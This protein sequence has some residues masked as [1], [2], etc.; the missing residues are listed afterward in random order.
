MRAAEA[1]HGLGRIREH[2]RAADCAIVPVT[3][4]GRLPRA[5]RTGSMKRST[6]IRTN[7]KSASTRAKSSSVGDLHRASR[8]RAP[9]RTGMPIARRA[10]HRRWPCTRSAFARRC[11]ALDHRARKSLRRLRAQEPRAIRRAHD[12]AALVDLLERVRRRAAPAIAPA[13]CAPS[14]RRARS[15]LVDHRARRIVHEHDAHFRREIL[16]PV[17]APTRRARVRRQ[18]RAGGRCRTER[19][20]AADPPRATSAARRPPMATSAR[21]MNAARCAGASA[22]PPPIETA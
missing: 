3:N 19:S 16:E 18:R 20:T 2:L 5:T 7:C 15:C 14:R 8:S 21:A 22:F 12:R 9:R 13:P 10:R 17:D 6:L 4:R 11:A 1:V